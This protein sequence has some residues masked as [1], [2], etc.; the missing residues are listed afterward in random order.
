MAAQSYNPANTKCAG[1]LSIDETPRND[2]NACH[3]PST[4]VTPDQL[5][6]TTLENTAFYQYYVAQTGVSIINIKNVMC[7]NIGASNS[8]GFQV[9][10]FTGNCGALTKLSCEQ[11]FGTSAQSTTVSLPAGTHV[12]V[13]I[14]GVGGSNC[15]YEITAFNAYGVLASGFKNFSVWKQTASNKLRWD[16]ENDTASWYE[17]ERSSDGVRFTT[18]G[19]IKTVSRGQNHYSFEDRNFSTLSLYRVKQVNENGKILLSDIVKIT[20]TAE[21]TFTV[22][23][24]TIVTD[25][26]NVNLYSPEKE[27]VEY[28]L[29]SIGGVLL[30]QGKLVCQQGENWLNRSML[31]M[32]AG[33]YLVTFLCKGQKQSL[34]FIKVH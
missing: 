7:D 24:A 9:G 13:A 33:R 2:N 4:E 23:A 30:T 12:T 15:K 17:I 3:K 14:D 18:I 8:N 16:V 20:R 19:K 31:N 21:A 27:T 26:L 29:T 10:F 6:A 28:W 34:S 5:C 22:K 1:A 32:P 11:L 25:Y